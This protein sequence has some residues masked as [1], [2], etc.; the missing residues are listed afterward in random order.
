MLP[1]G[2]LRLDLAWSGR[3]DMPRSS[4]PWRHLPYSF[5]YQFAIG[6]SF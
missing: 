3:D 5:A 4:A 1:F 6:P 2:P